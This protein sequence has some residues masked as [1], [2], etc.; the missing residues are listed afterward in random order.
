[1][2]NTVIDVEFQ[3]VSKY[4]GKE[5]VV[6]EV[7]FRINRG[8]IFVLIG[9]SGCGKTT[10]LKMINQLVPHSSG[11]I[12]VRGKNV[13]ELDPVE[14]RRS[15]GYVIQHIGLLPHLTIRDNVNFV[16]QLQRVP[17][18]KQRERANELIKMIG[19]PDSYL[20]RYPHEISGGEQQRVGVARALAA[21]PEILLM[22]EPFGAVDPLTREQL[23][24][25]LLRLQKTIKKTMVFVTHDMQEAFKVGNR[26]GIMRRGQLVTMG[27]A[28]DIVNAKDDFVRAFIGR[29]AVFSA[30]DTIPVFQAIIRD[31]PVI[32]EGDAIDPAD[33]RFK[34]WE[35]VFVINQN[36]HCLGYVSLTDFK[37]HEKVTTEKLR[38]IT[39][40]CL[41]SD[42]LK[43]AI[44][45][46]LWGKR[47]W[48]P[49]VTKEGNFEGIV[50]F[51]SCVSIL[52]LDD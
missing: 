17:Q 41:P 29:E 23:Q 28:M 25:E 32:H 50:S 26:I 12:F 33:P 27:T 4:Y 22:D 2:E 47:A 21:D 44:G 37:A 34:D 46:M 1:M 42:S 15:I 9:P 19:L 5:K 40:P 20:D 8:E 30:L 38:E 52:A 45:E 10:T 7:N 13:T 39:S 14:L 35:N 24:N 18:K 31:C 43:K 36:G 3:N 49:V 48:L 6:D 16:L 11:Q 51:Q